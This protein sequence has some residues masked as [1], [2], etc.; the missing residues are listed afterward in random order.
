ME[1][2]D[3][4]QFQTKRN[5]NAEQFHMYFVLTQLLSSVTSRQHTA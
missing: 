2:T 3:V 5:I 1:T 4:F